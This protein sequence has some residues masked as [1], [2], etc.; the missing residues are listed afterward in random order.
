MSDDSD[1]PSWSAEC[2]YNI[3][4]RR[5]IQEYDEILYSIYSDDRYDLDEDTDR[6]LNM[7]T[8]WFVKRKQPINL[9]GCAAYFKWG[10]ERT[11]SNLKKLADQ[12]A[13]VIDGRKIYPTTHYI[14][15]S[16]T[17]GKYTKRFDAL[18][19]AFRKM[20]KDQE[21]NNERHKKRLAE[22]KEINRILKKVEKKVWG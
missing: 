2:E 1:W 10:N 4:F 17:S 6:L 3:F 11:R 7:I 19:E 5:I 12:K 13:I 18:S 8:G 22:L 16:V 14:R 15:G 9:S 21:E 20:Q